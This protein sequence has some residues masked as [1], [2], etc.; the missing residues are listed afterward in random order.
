MSLFASSLT[1][2]SN[3]AFASLGALMLL[4]LGA[5][6]FRTRAVARARVHAEAST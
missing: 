6:A 5:W 3:V 2:T 1:R 4:A